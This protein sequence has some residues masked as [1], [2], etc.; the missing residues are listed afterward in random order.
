MVCTLKQL[1]D[2]GHYEEACRLAA[3]AWSVLRTDWP[4]EAERFNSVL[5]YLT[6]RQAKSSHTKED[7]S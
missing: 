3:E 6:A 1:G 4:Q 2:A 5:Q 7:R